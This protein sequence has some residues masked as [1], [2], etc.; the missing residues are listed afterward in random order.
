MLT[1]MPSARKN[2]SVILEELYT[3]QHII[4]IITYFFFSEA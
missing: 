1:A 3:L 4:I 2:M